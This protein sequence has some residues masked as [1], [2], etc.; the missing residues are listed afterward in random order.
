MID[1][2]PFTSPFVTIAHIDNV[3]KVVTVEESR[4]IS[5]AKPAIA[6]LYSIMS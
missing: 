2:P 3:V 5:E 4:T 1:L 6:F